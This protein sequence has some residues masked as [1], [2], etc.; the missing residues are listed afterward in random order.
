MNPIKKIWDGLKFAGGKAMQGAAFASMLG[1]MGI[2]I[3]FIQYLKLGMTI[4]ELGKSRGADKA[5]EAKDYALAIAK[6]NGVDVS[7]VPGE[8]ID[9][10]IQLLLSPATNEVKELAFDVE[11]AASDLRRAGVEDGQ[12]VTRALESRMSLNQGVSV[13]R[14]I[15]RAY[16]HDAI[17]LASRKRPRDI[18]I[19]RR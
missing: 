11:K 3:P 13:R 14:A 19:R 6:E 17:A 2:P 15:V 1:D 5:I 9:L 12:Q 18:L 7:K 8:A 10:L 4:A 16:T